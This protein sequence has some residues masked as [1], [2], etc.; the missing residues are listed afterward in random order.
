METK[1]LNIY[2]Q[3]PAM[4][5]SHLL[6][7][8][9]FPPFKA[10]IVDLKI[11]EGANDFSFTLKND[12][13]HL[14]FQWDGNKFFTVSLLK[15]TGSNPADINEISIAGYEKKNI[16]LDT[17]LTGRDGEDFKQ[18][19]DFLTKGNINLSDPLFFKAK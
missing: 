5:W 13:F 19:I 8:K 3:N 6:N 2:E 4:L 18:I 10:E 12:P 16:Q 17:I 1:T 11:T 7:E 9:I 15:R 14:K